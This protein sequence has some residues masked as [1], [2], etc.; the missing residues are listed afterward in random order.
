MKHHA[1]NALAVSRLSLVQL[2]QI[3]L[4]SPLEANLLLVPSSVSEQ[5]KVLKARMLLRQDSRS[6]CLQVLRPLAHPPLLVPD[7]LLVQ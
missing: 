2:Q 4:L 1:Q 7:L 3:H 5:L 6:E